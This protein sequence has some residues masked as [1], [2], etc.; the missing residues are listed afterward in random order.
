MLLELKNLTAGYQGNTVLN[1]ISLNLK[2]G[3][4]VALIG[5]NGAGKSTVLKAIFGLAQVTAGSIHY[6]GQ[7]ITGQPTHR[8]LAR[9]LAYVPQG[10]L[11]FS[12]LTVEDNLRL[13]AYLE[14]DRRVVARRLAEIFADLPVLAEKR[15]VLARHLSG[16]QQQLVALARALMCRPQVL[17]LDEPSLGLAPKVVAEVF[18][19]FRR[20][21]EQ[22][23]SMI[24]V[25]QNVRAALPIADRCYVL[26][27]GQVRYDGTPDAL[28]N[29]ER[30][31]ELF[32]G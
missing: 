26:V 12:R 15:R 30:L 8:L 28:Q 1:D 18:G 25:E 5:P 31:R 6:A 14:R 10:R 4:T 16:G 9:G 13:G 21:Q 3:E 22:A 11:V 24:I 19:H 20:F 32:L 29:P 17:L 27:N 2:D 7:D 23:L